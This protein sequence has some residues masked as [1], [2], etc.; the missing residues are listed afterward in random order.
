MAQVSNDGIFV[1]SLLNIHRTAMATV[2][3]VVAGLGSLFGWQIR[4]G[5][6][7]GSNALT[8]GKSFQEM[9]PFV[10]RL[11]LFFFLLGGQGGLVLLAYEGKPILES[12]HAVSALVALSLLFI[13]VT[14]PL[15]VLICYVT[16]FI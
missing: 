8:L 10:M 12:S 1:F 4:L 2:I 11:A 6:G 13:Q 14:Y 5:N 16:P 7:L 15:Q 3:F 9:H